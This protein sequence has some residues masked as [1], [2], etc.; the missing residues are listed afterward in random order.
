M[1]RKLPHSTTGSVSVFMV[2]LPQELGLPGNT[3]FGPAHGKC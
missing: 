1:R 2:L 3:G